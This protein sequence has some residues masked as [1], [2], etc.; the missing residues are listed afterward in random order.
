MTPLG[1][2]NQQPELVDNQ[3]PGDDQQPVCKSTW[4]VEH[5]LE[6]IEKEY[7]IGKLPE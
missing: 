7:T 3:T 2:V 6:K 5:K 1:A 4:F